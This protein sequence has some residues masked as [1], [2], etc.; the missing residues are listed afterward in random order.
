MVSTILVYNMILIKIYCIFFQ[1][2]NCLMEKLFGFCINLS[3]LLRCVSVQLWNLFCINLY[4]SPFSYLSSKVVLKY[5]NKVWTYSNSNT[6]P[7]YAFI[8]NSSDVISPIFKFLHPYVP[9]SIMGSVDI[10]NGLSP[11]LMTFLGKFKF[12]HNYVNRYLP[13]IVSYLVLAYSST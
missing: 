12:N 2:T 9:K 5:Y 8:K 10:Q 7:T 13:K 6:S 1:G 11:P 4:K 3:D